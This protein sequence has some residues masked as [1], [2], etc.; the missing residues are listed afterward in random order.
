M[1][2]HVHVVAEPAFDQELIDRIV[3]AAADAA[4]RY[5]VSSGTWISGDDAKAIGEYVA[6]AARAAFVAASA[7]LALRRGEAMAEQ[8]PTSERSREQV[9]LVHVANEVSVIHANVRGLCGVLGIEHPRE[10]Q[11]VGCSRDAIT[12]QLGADLV[13]LERALHRLISLRC[14]QVSGNV[15]T[16]AIPPKEGDSGSSPLA[17]GYRR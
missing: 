7:P 6:R 12:E 5:Y 11:G 14:E 4:G 2:E 17:W 3:V 9:S 8:Q 10:V 15:A 1:A 13:A 16:Q